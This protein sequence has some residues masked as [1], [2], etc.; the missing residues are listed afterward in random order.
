[1]GLSISV[2]ILFYFLDGWVRVDS[3]KLK[4]VENFLK[5]EFNRHTININ[6]ATF[7]NYETC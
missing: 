4:T 2:P 7:A 1:M 5:S 6:I 3:I